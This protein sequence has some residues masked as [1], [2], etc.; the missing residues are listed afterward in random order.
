MKAKISQWDLI[1]L[2]SLGTA[3]ETINKMKRK[4]T[5]WGKKFSSNVTDM[6]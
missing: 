2:G 3:K 4:P 5:E 1:K 6:G